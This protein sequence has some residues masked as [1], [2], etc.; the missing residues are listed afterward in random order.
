MF[1]YINKTCQFYAKKNI[2]VEIS[3]I[4]NFMK[5][6]GYYSVWFQ[7][8]PFSF[9]IFYQFWQDAVLADLIN[10]LHPKWIVNYHEHDSLLEN[11]ESEKMTE[12][13]MKAAWEAYEAEKS[14]RLGM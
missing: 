14:G 1:Y 11:I 3:I 5:R 8:T 9:V 6:C 4:S 7:M 10:R 13:E 2:C 12:E